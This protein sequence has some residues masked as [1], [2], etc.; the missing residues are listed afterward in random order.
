MQQEF[1]S[2]FIHSLPVFEHSNKITCIGFDISIKLSS[3]VC[4]YIRTIYTVN[5]F[6][7]SPGK[8]NK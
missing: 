4:Q 5:K 3:C 8:I 2:Q 6:Y 7:L 1:V